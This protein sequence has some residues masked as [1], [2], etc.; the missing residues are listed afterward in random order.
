MREQRLWRCLDAAI[1][2]GPCYSAEEINALWATETR[3]NAEVASLK[4]RIEQLHA[5]KQKSRGAAFDKPSLQTFGPSV[6]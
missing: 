6:R 3:L 5:V 2:D 4:K 1:A